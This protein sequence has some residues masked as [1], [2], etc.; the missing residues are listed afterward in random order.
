MAQ[1]ALSHGSIGVQTWLNWGSAMAQLGTAMAQLGLSHG[2]TGAQ[3][4]QVDRW[5]RGEVG[6]LGFAPPPRQ[7]ILG[8]QSAT[9]GR[10]GGVACGG[11]DG[12]SQKNRKKKKDFDEEKKDEYEN[13]D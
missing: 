3:P 4:W 6:L 12:G 1:L 11:G 5:N 9:S 2:S 8:T 7:R 13:E 10:G